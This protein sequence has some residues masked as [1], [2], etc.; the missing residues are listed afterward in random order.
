MTSSVSDQ[1][2]HP[3][4]IELPFCKLCGE[5]LH[6]A[7][8]EPALTAGFDRRFYECIKC[9]HSFVVEQEQP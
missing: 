7:R 5:R 6:L 8:L 3:K 1:Q 4:Q 9:G 2:Y